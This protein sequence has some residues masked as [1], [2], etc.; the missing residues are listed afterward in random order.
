VGEGR[1]K[2]FAIMSILS[3]LILILVTSMAL[4]QT[5]ELASGNRYIE[6]SLWLTASFVIMVSFTQLLP[7]YGFDAAARPEFWWLRITLLFS[8]ALIF[9]FNSLAIFIIPGLWLVAALS[10]VVPS[11]IEKDAK[12]PSQLGLAVL[13]IVSVG[14]I[15]ITSVTEN[16]LSNLLLLG[17][18]PMIISNVIVRTI[19]DD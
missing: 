9:W 15:F 17:S 4:R 18:I 14:I 3:L 1:T 8:P 7:R 5:S 16:M 6:E 10:I 2:S 11:I 13:L 12:T 19:V